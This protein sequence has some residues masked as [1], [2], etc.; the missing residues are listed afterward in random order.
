MRFM[1]NQ[2]GL[3]FKSNRVW[4]HAAQVSKMAEASGRHSPSG[5]D[6]DFVS[7][8]EDDFQCLI[9]HLPLKDPVQTRCGHR[10]CKECLEEHFRWCGLLYTKVILMSEETFVHLSTLWR[11]EFITF[12][13]V[14]PLLS[15]TVD[16]KDI[17]N[18]GSRNWGFDY[19]LLN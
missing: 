3:I 11:S 15:R 12:L 14:F 2:Y 8:V 18:S 4:T 13:R 10:F 5:H 6:E 1:T 17:G 7:E 9:C 19:L 16:W